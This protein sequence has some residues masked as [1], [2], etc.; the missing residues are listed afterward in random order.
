LFGEVEAQYRANL[1]AQ[2]AALAEERTRLSKAREN[3][4]AEQVKVKLEA[5][6]P[7]IAA[8][9]AFDKLARDNFP[10]R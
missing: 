7:I 9:V 8:G 1:A 2:E 6:L 5:V 3:C 10:G 4:A